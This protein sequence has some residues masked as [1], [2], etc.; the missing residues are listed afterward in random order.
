MTELALQKLG[1]Y[2]LRDEIGRGG[3]G[4]VYEAQ[5]E[6]T[7][8]VVALKVLPGTFA[9]GSQSVER[10]HRE[11]RAAARLDHP[12]VVPV[13]DVGSLGGIH[14]VAM[15]RLPGPNLERAPI[16]DWRKAAEAVAEV[17]DALEAAHRAGIVHRDVTP[18]N[19]IFRDD[20]RLALSDFGLAKLQDAASLTFTGETLGTPRYMSP[21]QLEGKEVG[22]R[23]DIYQ[24]GLTLWETL[25][26]R[27]PYAGIASHDRY[28]AALQEDPAS[29]R[30]YNRHVPREVASVTLKA[31]ARDLGARYASAADFAADLRR[32]LAG[33]P[34]TASVGRSGWAA[35]GR[36]RALIQRFGFAPISLFL[37]LMAFLLTLLSWAIGSYF[38][39]TSPLAFLPLWLAP[40]FVALAVAVTGL[41]VPTKWRMLDLVA[42]ALGGL[43]SVGLLA[44]I[45]ASE[46]SPY[47]HLARNEEVVARI[48]MLLAPLAMGVAG[49]AFLASGRWKRGVASAAAGVIWAAWFLRWWGPEQIGI[50]LLILGVAAG[51]ALWRPVGGW[52]GGNPVRHRGA[53]VAAG[54]LALSIAGWIVWDSKRETFA[55]RVSVYRAGLWGPDARDIQLITLTEPQSWPEDLTP[56]ALQVEMG[57]APPRTPEELRLSLRGSIDPGWNLGGRGATVIDLINMRPDPG[58]LRGLE[59]SYVVRKY[60]NFR[61]KPGVQLPDVTSTIHSFQHANYLWADVF[62]AAARGL[63]LEN[64]GADW[65]CQAAAPRAETRD[66]LRKGWND[67]DVTQ[68]IYRRRLHLLAIHRHQDLADTE[69]IREQTRDRDLGLRLLAR[70]SLAERA[71]SVRTTLMESVLKEGH[72][73]DEPGFAYLAL[74]RLVGPEDLETLDRFSAAHLPDQCRY[75]VDCVRFSR[76]RD[77]FGG[78]MRAALAS[79]P[80][81]RYSHYD[82][83]LLAND[84]VRRRRD[85]GGFSLQ[86]DLFLA[87]YAV[88]MAPALAAHPPGREFLHAVAERRVD[89]VGP[90]RGNH[91]LSVQA[92]E[93]LAAACELGLDDRLREGWPKLL[94]E[95]YRCDAC[96]RLR[97]RIALRIGSPKEIEEAGLELLRTIDLAAWAPLRLME[98]LATFDEVRARLSP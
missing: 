47:F 56:R 48:I 41:G 90:P 84:A 88:D 20:G 50:D 93:A 78:L 72:F 6:A 58:V 40:C 60:L 34:V 3:M 63:P 16:R 27:H 61:D 89:A 70:W 1:P 30:A 49:A 8:R 54:A 10:F 83:S 65:H 43:L 17:A 14:F 25:A 52:L 75:V 9:L 44:G 35:A 7:G 98:G 4:I 19:L 24:L 5:D 81:T 86:R 67:P 29:P 92:F 91:P 66:L 13:Y 97:W 21:E 12:A 71:P 26:G 94:V 32:A 37:I 96:I 68:N 18:S 36:V 51:G 82:P 28:R 45:F 77:D 53:A 62:R 33:E 69:W 57:V 22:P 79:S 42:V 80:S 55:Y 23:S 76:G 39:M 73:D 38:G 85:P 31:M 15:K 87:G 59:E 46:K 64:T 95:S 2:R 74:Q 11:A